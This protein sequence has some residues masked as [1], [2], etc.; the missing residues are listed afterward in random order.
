MS[1]L[2]YTTSSQHL[3][4]S[5][6]TLLELKKEQKMEESEGKLKASLQYLSLSASK[7]DDCGEGKFR[8][9]SV[10]PGHAEKAYRR[11]RRLENG[12]REG[13]VHPKV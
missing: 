6:W 12:A 8:E 13:N 11:R 2:G 10:T 5:T 4:P 1:S 3:A 7:T 9:N